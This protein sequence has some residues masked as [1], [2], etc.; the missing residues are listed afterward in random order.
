VGLKE[1][2]IMNVPRVVIAGLYGE[3]G[4]TTI[5]TGLIGAFKKKGFRVQPFKIGPDYIDGGYHTEVA[6]RPSR[7]IDA[8]LTSPR[9]VLEIFEYNC[10]NADLAVIEGFMGL[11]DGI[12]RVIA[13]SQEYG[14]TSHIAQ[15]LKANVI[16]VLDVTGM[17]INAATIVHGFKSF[18][19]KVKVKGVILNNIRSMQ[20]AEWM[21]QTIEKATKVP[22]VGVI[23]YSQEIFLPTRLGGLIPIS[24]RKALKTTLSKLVD[25]VGERVDI[26]K[27]FEIAKDLEELPE[28]DNEIFP[29]QPKEKKVRL[30]L[31]FDEAFNFYFPTNIDL[32][33]AQGADTLFFSPVHDN[34]LPSNLDGLYLP[35]GFPDIVAEQLSRN[36]T[37]R[38]SIKD[39]AE[40]GMPIYSEHG[41]SL[42]LTKAIDNF[43]G[44]TF[45]MVGA[46]PSKA[47]MERKLQ[48]LDSTLMETINDNLLC[49]KGRIVHGHEYHFS[50]II[51]IPKDAKFAFK[52]RIGKGITGKHEGWIEHNVMA[53]HGAIHLGFNKEFAENLIK[54][55]ER[56]R[57]K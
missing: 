43:E 24:E 45:P 27:I 12:T 47:L 23:P 39:A 35:G 40:D 18:N 55:C 56:Y 37:M 10:R 16:L 20:Q 51:D 57:Q 22:I 11:F 1:K 49:Q 31:A 28:I 53:L 3:G 8:W 5:A 32:L 2:M 44:E 33:R 21:K 7:H 29:A 48:A 54:H 4:K 46:L 34:I 19:E 14:S 6:N 26:D 17:R 41:G 42:Y 50:R 36:Q 38:K 52:T 15:I 13:G 25:Y 9:T 30:G